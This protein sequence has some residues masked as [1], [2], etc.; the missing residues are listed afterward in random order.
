MSVTSKRAQGRRLMPKAG[1]WIGVA[2]LT[3]ALIAGLASGPVRAEQYELE[4]TVSVVAIDRELIAHAANGRTSKLRLEV[5]ERIRWHGA[6]GR[7]GFAVSNRRVLG[8]RQ[9]TGWTALDLRVGEVSTLPPG[10]GPRLALLVTTQRAIAFDGQWAQDSI[11]PQ[12]V[13]SHARVGSRVALVVTQRRALGVAPG[14]AGF[15][16]VSLQIHEGVESVRTMAG[17]GEITTRRR[18][19]FFSGPGGSWSERPRTLH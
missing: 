15:V 17:S 3:L 13:V 2:A 1:R 5:G 10:L 7:I 11:G 19:L 4:D 12:E 14:G 16:P 6:R 9:T 8:F 18:L